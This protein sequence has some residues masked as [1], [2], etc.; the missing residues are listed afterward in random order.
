MTPPN[1][2]LSNSEAIARETRLRSGL[3]PQRAL[4]LIVSAAFKTD[5]KGDDN[6]Q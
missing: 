5:D 3:V 4:I 2:S 6:Q 1:S